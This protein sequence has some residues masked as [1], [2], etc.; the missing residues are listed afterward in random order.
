MKK[1][2]SLILLSV[3]MYGVLPAQTIEDFEGPAIMMAISNPGIDKSTYTLVPNPDPSEVNTSRTVLK[4]AHD[5]DI[6]GWWGY[7]HSIKPFKYDPTQFLHLKLWRPNASGISCGFQ[8]Y[9]E[10]YLNGQE[11]F[12]EFGNSPMNQPAVANGWEELVFNLTDY[13]VMAKNFILFPDFGGPTPDVTLFVDDI[14]INHDPAVGSAPELVIEDFEHIPLNVMLGGAEDKSTMEIAPNPDPDPEGA[15]LSA[16]VIKFV[17]DKDG[18]PW[19]GFWSTLSKPVDVSV[20]KYMHVKVWKPR[21]SPV[22]FK[23]EGG[24]AGNLEIESMNPQTK[25]NEW[26]D[27]V[28]DLSSKAGMYPTIAFMPDFEDPLTL[29]EDMVMYFD[30]IVLNNDPS[31]RTTPEVTFH[32]DMNDAGLTAGQ[33]VFISGYFGGEEGRWLYPGTFSG[34]EMTDSDGDGIYSVTRKL[35]DGPFMFRFLKG[36]PGALIGD[37]GTSVRTIEV[38]GDAELNFKWQVGQV[39]DSGD[40]IGKEDFNLIADGKFDNPGLMGST[41]L[42]LA[43]AKTVIDIID[44]SLKL[45]NNSGQYLTY[46]ISTRQLLND[47]GKMLYNDSLYILMFDAWA[48]KERECSFLIHDNLFNQ[49]NLLGISKDLDANNNYSLWSIPLTT[50]RMKYVRTFTLKG[51]NP[52]STF[53]FSVGS[54]IT[55]GD[56]YLDDV[57]LFAASD[58]RESGGQISSITVTGEGGAT[59][60]SADK[61]TLQMIAVVAPEDAWVNSVQWS[62]D[63]SELATIDD[64][65]L[66]T[67]LR[68]GK[69]TV[70]ATA[71]DGS[72]ISGSREITITNQEVPDLPIDFE[73]VADA[74]WS[75]TDNGSLHPNDLM[76]IANP[77]KSPYNK[78]DHVL[79]LRINEDADKYVGICTSS[80]APLS[81]ACDKYTLQMWVRKSD[82]RPVGV[83]LENSATGGKDTLVVEQLRQA[84]VW[85]RLRFD[86][87][88]VNNHTYGKITI[89]PDITD[90]RSQRSTVYIDNIEM[91]K[92]TPFNCTT[93]T[94]FIA[95]DLVRLYPN[96][97]GSELNV[98]LP[99]SDAFL[100]VYDA[101][102]SKKQEFRIQGTF[103]TLDLSNYIRGVYFLRINH[104]I[105]V[106]FVK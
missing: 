30:E 6:E 97:A 40:K 100:E 78:S 71:L 87:P 27:L 39:S 98:E 75:V 22:K 62:V 26:E 106:K 1:F 28:F 47:W 92:S 88:S 41:W 11:E 79:R 2:T 59:E 38:S 34:V 54:G 83:K 37:F 17:R 85:V 44:G 76:I 23:I 99:F 5:K 9:Y 105:V 43:G 64:R 104:D 8:S 74:A 84:D 25:V 102:G 18:I 86:F 7:F 56:V 21:I 31:P 24:A 69:V 36:T 63:D 94:S 4:C 66:L 90:D 50:A 103:T 55:S 65:G 32:V 82:L 42:D 60:I 3:F 33:K 81:L 49:Y 52:E 13:T 20:N 29:T 57:M 70:I 53:A 12:F 51:A 101:L 68:N 95:Q 15:N 16:Y 10:N 96:P 35:P 48:S 91:V 14:Y 58:I 72:A 19:G 61:A 80:F 73:Q 77:Y 46:H 93:G 45:S 89:Y 67:G